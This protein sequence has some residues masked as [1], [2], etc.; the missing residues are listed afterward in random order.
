MS[1]WE[2][3]EARDITTTHAQEKDICKYAY[4]SWV[5][6]TGCACAVPRKLAWPR[7]ALVLLLYF[8]PILSV[9]HFH[10]RRVEASIHNLPIYRTQATKVRD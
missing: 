2:L 4:H 8:Y 6:C 5:L 9:R 3:R 1:K 7:S 10:P